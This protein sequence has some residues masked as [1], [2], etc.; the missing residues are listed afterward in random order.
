MNTS[1]TISN[2]SY[3]TPAKLA[4]VFSELLRDGVIDWAYWIHHKA[5][6][7]ETKDHAHIVLKPAARLDTVAL[8]KRFMEPD[9]KASIT[10]P[11]GV[12]SKWNFC[13]SLDDWLLY[14]V[15]DTGY[16]AS[17]GQRRRYHYTIDD[18]QATDREALLEDWRSIDRRAFDR[19]AYVAFAAESGVPFAL[20]VKDGR[21]PVAQYNAYKRYYEDILDL[22]RA[23]R[24]RRQQ[25]HE[26]ELEGQLELQGLQLYDRSTGEAVPLYD[27]FEPAPNWPAEAF[28]EEE[29]E[30]D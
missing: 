14:A 1:R 8:A 27:G 26:E 21:V 28:G 6:D 9:P 23:A 13:R 2:I 17:K 30:G 29:Q 19:L 24:T 20:L 11:L 15:H 7:E 12:T 18:V 25:E 10:K 5:D 3:N 16:L 22:T 4:A